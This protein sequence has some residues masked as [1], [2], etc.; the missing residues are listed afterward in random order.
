MFILALKILAALFVA[1]ILVVW[2]YIYLQGDSAVAL[3]KEKVGAPVKISCT[4][5]QL[6]FYVDIPCLNAGKEEG[7]ILDAFLRVYLPEEQYDGVRI[8]GKVNLAD[9]PRQD[10]YFEAELIGAGV[11]KMLRLYLE[12][13]PKHGKSMQEALAE[14]PD[15]EIG[16]FV[17]GRGRTALRYIKEYIT[18]SAADLRKFV[19]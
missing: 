3:V 9:K 11:T 5:E 13:C 10:D 8:R 18:I 6:D 15:Y 1:A 2:L 14:L 16:V 12:V 19:A 4:E 7:T 17:E